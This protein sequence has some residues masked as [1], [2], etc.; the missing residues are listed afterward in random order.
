MYVGI[1][2]DTE[3]SCR[4]YQIC[5][6]VAPQK[7]S[8]EASLLR[9]FLFLVT[10]FVSSTVVTTSVSSTVVTTSMSST[11]VTTSVSVMVQKTDHLQKY[12]FQCVDTDLVPFVIGYDG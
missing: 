6:P 9:F 1:E 3:T 12:V 11:V 7:T 10:V 5:K 8:I 2:F 4:K